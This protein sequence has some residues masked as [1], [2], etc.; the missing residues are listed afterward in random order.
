MYSLFLAE[1]VKF[2]EPYWKAHWAPQNVLTSLVASPLKY[3]RDTFSSFEKKSWY[4]FSIIGSDI[5]WESQGVSV[6]RKPDF[7]RLIKSHKEGQICS[8]L[9]RV[10][11]RGSVYKGGARKTKAHSKL[12][13]AR[14]TKSNKKGSHRSTSCKTNIVEY[15]GSWLSRAEYLGTGRRMRHSVILPSVITENWPS[16]IRGPWHQGEYLEQGRLTLTVGWSV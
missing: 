4:S 5:S 11:W 1:T 15:R 10:D 3:V 6:S 7:K 12:N 13:L 14:G 9:E 16:T 8:C 2:P